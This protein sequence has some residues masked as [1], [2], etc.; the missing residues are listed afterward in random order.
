M[1][2]EI[3]KV[4]KFRSE[5]GFFL[6]SGVKV[7]GTNVGTPL[8]VGKGN[9]T[10]KARDAILR[11]RRRGRGRDCSTALTAD[12]ACEEYYLTCVMWEGGVTCF[13]NAGSTAFVSG[14]HG[15]QRCAAPPR[16]PSI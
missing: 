3:G 14:E 1:S 12:A 11:A 4:H 2:I 6:I 13:V 7:W 5:K 16:T 8:H 10:K 9:A 15:T